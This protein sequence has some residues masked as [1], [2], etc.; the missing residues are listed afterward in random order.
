MNFKN[1]EKFMDSLTDWVIPGNSVSVYKDNE[2]VFRY[3]SGFA[4]IESKTKMRGDELMYIYSCSKVATVTAAMQLL[5]QGK[6]LLSDPLYEYIPEFKDM[7]VKDADGNIEK[8]KNVITIRNIF[9]MTG[10]FDYNLEKLK[11]P[12]GSDEIAG[13]LSTLECVKRLA[14]YP[15][16]D[17]PGTHWGYSLCHDILAGVVEAVSGERF[18]NYMKKNIFE[19]CGM[20]DTSYH[21]SKEDM[22]KM[23][24]Q[25]S[26]EPQ[27]E[28]GADLVE[29][30]KSGVKDGDLKRTDNSNCF[31]VSDE[32]DSGGA[33]IVTKVGEYAKFVSALANGGISPIGERIISRFA[34]DLLRTNQLTSVTMPYF[35]WAAVKG[36]GYGLGVRTLTDRAKGGALSPLGEF[37]WG[38]AAGATVLVDPENRLGVFYAHHM[39]NPLEDYY[40][41]RLRNGVY[42]CLD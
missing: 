42:S 20:T 12:Y 26:F 38:G 25:Y 32:Y 2:E 37:G 34:V 17:E 15:L 28:H 18:E 13:D 8:C 41:P 14:A 24:T 30:Q 4:D 16:V 23:A 31:I 3:S 29:L 7:T 10:G 19:P 11:K 36:Y 40:Q 39:L 21:I 5:E 6:I 35:N 27:S 1:L 33:G 22:P 9:T